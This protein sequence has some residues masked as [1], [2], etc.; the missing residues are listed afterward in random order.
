MHFTAGPL[1][2]SA[3]PLMFIP[4]SQ[5]H[6]TKFGDLGLPTKSRCEVTHSL[7]PVLMQVMQSEPGHRHV[8]LSDFNSVHYCIDLLVFNGVVCS[9][10]VSVVLGG[11]LQL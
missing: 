8:F 3:L 6:L 4:G 7:I 5:E 11:R 1:C 9:V 2:S 10:Q